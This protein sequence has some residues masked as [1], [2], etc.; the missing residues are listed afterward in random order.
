V[1]AAQELIGVPTIGRGECPAR[2]W[3]WR[4]SKKS[5]KPSKT[6]GIYENGAKTAGIMHLL[7]YFSLLKALWSYTCSKFWKSYTPPAA[8]IRVKQRIL[9]FK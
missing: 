9:I 8:Q 2:G 3:W 7:T 6:L 4:E 1:R 5:N